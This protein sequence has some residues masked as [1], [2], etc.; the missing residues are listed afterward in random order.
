MFICCEWFI[1]EAARA[2]MGAWDICTFCIA[3]GLN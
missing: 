1:G 3:M 2:P